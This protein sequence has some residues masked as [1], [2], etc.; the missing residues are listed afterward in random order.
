[1]GLLASCYSDD[2]ER[3]KV[4]GLAVAGLSLGI[5]GLKND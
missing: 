4:M 2:T 3:G 5:T 1:M